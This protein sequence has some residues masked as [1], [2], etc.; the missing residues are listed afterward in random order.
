M[1]RRLWLLAIVIIVAWASVASA[2]LPEM[3]VDRIHTAL[4]KRPWAISDREEL[5][6]QRS[7]RARRMARGLYDAVGELGVPYKRYLVAAAISIWWSETR[8]GL[9]VHRGGPSRW[10]SDDGRA[11]C[12]GQ[13]HERSVGI[14]REKNEPLLDFRKRQRE[15]WKSLAGTDYEATKRC[16]LATM[17]AFR[18][19]LGQCQETEEPW[20][21]AFGA[22]GHGEHHCDLLPTSKK[23]FRLMK[24]LIPQL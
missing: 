16:A 11:K 18:E 4:M 14:K 12:F 1:F 3:S 5:V 23:R 7:A 13:L 2:K 24:R 6:D 21:H 17:R 9:E 10:G 15:A 8:F 19:K 20:L 22:Y